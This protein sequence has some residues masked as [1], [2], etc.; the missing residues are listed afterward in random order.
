MVETGGMVPILAT[1]VV[2]SHG[3]AIPVHR[4]VNYESVLLTAGAT[5]TFVMALLAVVTKWGGRRFRAGVLEVTRQPLDDFQRFLRDLD[6]RVAYLEGLN[7]VSR[8]D[9]KPTA[10]VRPKQTAP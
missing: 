3:V 2:I 10:A 5:G 6:N 4:S 7:Q 1:S 8:P 9:V